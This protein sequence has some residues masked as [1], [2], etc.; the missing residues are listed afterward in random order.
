MK[1][2]LQIPILLVFP[3]LLVGCAA[4]LSSPSSKDASAAPSGGSNATDGNTTLSNGTLVS[5][6]GDQ[7]EDYAS[8][9]DYG[10]SLSMKLVFSNASLYAL[11][12]YGAQDSSIYYDVYFP[13]DLTITAG[14]K[15]FAYS[16]VGVRM[17]GNNSRAEIVSSDGSFKSGAYCHFKVSFKCTFDDNYYDLSL[18]SAFKHDWSSD[19]A[20]RSARKK[21]NFAGMEKLD[22]KYLPRNAASGSA[23]QTY[24]EDI[25]CYDVFNKMGVEAPHSKWASVTLSDGKGSKAVS[26]EAV[27]AMDS[28]FVKHH[29]ALDSGGDLY[30]CNTY[31]GA[32]QGSYIKADLTRSGA[33]ALTTGSDGKANG[34][35]VAKGK[36]GVEDNYT[37]YHPNYQLKTNDDGEN[38]DF[39]KM[40]TLIN[41]VYDVYSGK[42]GNSALENV[43]DVQ[44]FLAMEAVSY[45]LGNFDDQRN[46]YNNFFIYFR[47]S[48]GKAVYIPYDWDWSLGACMMI[49]VTSWAPYHTKTSHDSSNTNPLY[50]CTILSNSSLT[51][52]ITS[53]RSTYASTIK[54][55]VNAGY[56]TYGTYTGFVDSLQNVGGRQELSSVSSYMTSKT[57]VIASSSLS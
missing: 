30:K 7:G 55:L 9:W 3:F 50:W 54:A 13:A 37:D 47:P 15:T 41:T 46:N 34:A 20:G 35:R 1:K 6:S 28:C 8:F 14:D 56:L 40:A 33:V 53:Y 22:L 5:T 49:D 11:S 25:Y 23:Y 2:S 36:I 17:K 57:S 52:S 10:E 32:S 51:Y 19:A 48:D 31:T 38:S 12:Q 42:S 29:F 16:E 4:S 24:S 18:F 21:R 26:Y 44:E 39:S 43:L 45:C 27:E